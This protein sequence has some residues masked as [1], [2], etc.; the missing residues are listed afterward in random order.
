MRALPAPCAPC[1]HTGRPR[2]SL[3]SSY[4][5]GRSTGRAVARLAAK[6]LQTACREDAIIVAAAAAAAALVSPGCWWCPQCARDL[7]VWRV[8][9]HYLGCAQGAIAGRVGESSAA[10]GARRHQCATGESG[11]TAAR[12]QL[13]TRCA[14]RGRQFPNTVCCTLA[15][16]W[17]SGMGL[18]LVGSPADD[19]GRRV[20][21]PCL[22]F[23]SCARIS[24][25]TQ[26]GAFFDRHK[27]RCISPSA[28]PA[29]TS[30]PFSST[31]RTDQRCWLT[32]TSA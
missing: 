11:A 30:T 27:T 29:Q 15:V 4:L 20:C 16:L 23:A 31:Y 2:R 22:C 17:S 8:V 5:R 26:R 12:Q 9:T 28:S 10:F 3:A 25:H 1:Q 6:P 13:L 21:L 24:R 18:R 7:Y 14:F 19:P 32:K